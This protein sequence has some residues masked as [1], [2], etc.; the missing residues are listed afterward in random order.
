MSEDSNLK[1]ILQDDGRKQ[2]QKETEIN[3]HNFERNNEEKQSKLKQ[4][5]DT[6]MMN[7]I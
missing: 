4:I 6:N 2:A 5:N 7:K 3:L 1:R